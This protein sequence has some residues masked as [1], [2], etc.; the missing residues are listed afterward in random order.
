MHVKNPEILICPGVV[1][2]RSEELMKDR[3]GS[4]VCYKVMCLSDVGDAVRS[5]EREDHSGS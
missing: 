1:V 4:H 3:S 2:M 5:H